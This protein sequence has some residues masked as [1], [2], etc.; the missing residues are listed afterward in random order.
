MKTTLISLLIV[1]CFSLQAQET[2]IHITDHIATIVDDNLEF[3]LHNMEN[4][5]EDIEDV[6]FLADFVLD[7]FYFNCDWNDNSYD[8]FVDRKEN[9][10]IKLLE[11]LEQNEDV[12]LPEFKETLEEWKKLNKENTYHHI[13]YLK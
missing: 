1:F 6:K 3:A 11:I 7:D 13:D 8:I 10:K 2:H 9:V 4:I 12:F 5:L